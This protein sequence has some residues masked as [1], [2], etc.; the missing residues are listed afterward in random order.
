[1]TRDGLI[2]QQIDRIIDFL[3]TCG[4]VLIE[5]GVNA[6]VASR[7]VQEFRKGIGDAITGKSPLDPS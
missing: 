2:D 6:L 3:A 1:M 4:D 5:E 7:D